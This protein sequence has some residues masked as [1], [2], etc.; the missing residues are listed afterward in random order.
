[1]Q[2]T[3][4]AIIPRIHGA[5]AGRRLCRR[6]RGNRTPSPGSQRS[7]DR[8]SPLPRCRASCA[9]ARPMDRCTDDQRHAPGR[10]APDLRC[11]GARRVRLGRQVAV[12]AATECHIEAHRDRRGRPGCLWPAPR[13]SARGV[14]VD[15]ISERRRP[16]NVKRRQE[17][18]SRAASRSKA[19]SA[20]RL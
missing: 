10:P 5:A 4:A 7:A 6:D 18:R 19:T 16:I 15:R 8:R 11:R 13:G 2:A 9:A 3:G 14:H 12:H 20:S 1:M 17:A